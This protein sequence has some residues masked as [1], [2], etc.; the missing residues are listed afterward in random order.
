MYTADAADELLCGERGDRGSI[1]E[2][3][4]VVGLGGTYFFRRGR[5]FEFVIRNRRAE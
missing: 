2:L 1:K 3:Y 4:I 5:A